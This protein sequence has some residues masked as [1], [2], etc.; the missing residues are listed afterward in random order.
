RQPC[1][2]PAAKRHSLT[3]FATFTSSFENSAPTCCEF[4]AGC[5]WPSQL[6]QEAAFTMGTL[7]PCILWC[8][9]QACCYA[10]EISW[11]LNSL[12][13]VSTQNVAHPWDWQRR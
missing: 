5:P 2:L 7:S 4:A 13:T 9:L 12:K 11:M 8:D 6:V 1:A 10:R 3:S